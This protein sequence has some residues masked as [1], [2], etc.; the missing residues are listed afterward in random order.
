MQECTEANKS[1]QGA[2]IPQQSMLMLA[3]SNG[4][5]FVGDKSG[6]DKRTQWGE[7]A[8]LK[9]LNELIAGPEH[10]ALHD[11]LDVPPLLRL[12]PAQHQRTGFTHMLAP[13]SRSCLAPP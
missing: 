4:F 5:S 12:P 10:A 11:L 7:R 1:M 9:L 2:T 3:S 8:D 13:R 6:G